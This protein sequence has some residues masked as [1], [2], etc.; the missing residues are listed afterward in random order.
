LT[1]HDDVI[2]PP[3]PRLGLALDP[4]PARAVPACGDYHSDLLLLS[5]PSPGRYASTVADFLRG[6]ITSYYMVCQLLFNIGSVQQ[7]NET[8][9]K[10]VF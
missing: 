3:L 1:E 8:C 10:R 4:A 9:A 6:I 2:T 7:S 5:A